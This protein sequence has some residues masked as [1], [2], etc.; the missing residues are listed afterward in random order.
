MTQSSARK[1]ARWW[2]AALRHRQEHE[3][4]D[5]HRRD[6][7]GRHL[8]RIGDPVRDDHQRALSVRRVHRR[9][10]VRDRD[11]ERFCALAPQQKG[12]AA[13]VSGI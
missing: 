11:C 7:A 2:R 12:S 9:G 10:A 8:R 5:H 1:A 6:G 13:D 3:A 4:A